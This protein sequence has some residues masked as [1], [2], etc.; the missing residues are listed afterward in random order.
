MTP[1]LNYNNDDSG[2]LTEETSVILERF[3]NLRLSTQGRRSRKVPMSVLDEEL[4]KLHEEMRISMNKMKSIIKDFGI[5]LK[6][7]F[8]YGSQNALRK[9][10]K[11]DRNLLVNRNEAKKYKYSKQCLIKIRI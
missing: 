9:A 4:R 1:N 2:Y 8:R 10:L 7:C 5:C 6:N 11:N 3:Q